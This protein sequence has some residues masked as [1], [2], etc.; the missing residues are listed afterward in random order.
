MCV[1]WHRSRLVPVAAL[2]VV[3]AACGQPMTEGGATA[4]AA[5]GMPT[6]SRD[7]RGAA[8]ATAPGPDATTATGP[9]A[10]RAGSGGDRARPTT[11]PPT[12]VGDLPTGI[13]QP[14]SLEIPSIGVDAAL[15]GLSLGDGDPEVPT[16]WEDAGWYETTRNPGEIGPAVI[17]GHIDSKAGPAVFFRLRELGSGDEVIVH[18][19]DGQSRTFIVEDSGQYPKT[20][21]PDEVFGFGQARPELRLITCGGSFD[22]EVGHYV[23][24][25]VVYAHANPDA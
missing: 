11:T 23:D 2:V 9:G 5:T 6:T 19:T 20:A 18:G 15:V 22:S 10:P 17:A 13:E 14:V 25:L 3:L 7:V 16:R 8:T 4:P 1:R 21:L 24:N 12:R